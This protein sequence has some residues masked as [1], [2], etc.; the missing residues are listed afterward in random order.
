MIH[1]LKGAEIFSSV[2]E[3]IGKLDRVVL[4]PETKDGR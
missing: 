3:K 1:L 4:D 2:G